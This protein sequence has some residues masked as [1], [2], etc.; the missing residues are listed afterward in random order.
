MVCKYNSIVR[1]WQAT[2]LNR[3]VVGREGRHGHGLKGHA[4]KVQVQGG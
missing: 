1:H 3:T 4:G 2:G